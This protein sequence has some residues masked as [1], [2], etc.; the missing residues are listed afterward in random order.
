[1]LSFN[2]LPQLFCSQ[3][4]ILMELVEVDRNSSPVVPVPELREP[5]VYFLIHEL[6]QH[7][8]GLLS[9]LLKPLP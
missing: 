3:V 1:L 9:P 8:A 6:R 5:F 7:L 4:E 2:Y